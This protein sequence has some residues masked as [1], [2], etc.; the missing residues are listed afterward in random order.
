MRA[1]HICLFLFLLLAIAQLAKGQ[2]TSNFDQALLFEANKSF[3]QRELMGVTGKCLATDP[4]WKSRFDSELLEYCLNKLQAFLAARGYLRA[5]VGK[6]QKLQS[7]RGERFIIHVSEE[8]LYSLGAVRI[9][10]SKLLSSDRIREMLELKTGDVADGERIGAWLN[11][12]VA[13]VYKNFGYMRY[14]SEIVP[15]FHVKSATEGIVDLHVTIDEGDAFLVRSIRFEG[16]GRVPRETLLRQMTVRQGEVFSQELFNE[17]LKRIIQTGPFEIIDVDKDVDYR[18]DDKS[19]R[20][21]LTIH[22]RRK[23]S[24]KSSNELRHP[25]FP[26]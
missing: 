25:S 7:D 14:A 1:T 2:E 13:N 5:T 24:A 3:S 6:P 17:D 15:K 18:W 19:P 10:G 21:D 12:R 4:R 23:A 16:N 26:V 20:L 11:E 22:L 9:E 8:A